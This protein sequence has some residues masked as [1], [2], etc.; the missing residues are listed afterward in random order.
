MQ[1]P[2]DL[3]PA[4]A[5][6]P[7][8]VLLNAQRHTSDLAPLIT[9][10]FLLLVLGHSLQALGYSSMPLLPLYLEH[11]QADRTEISLIMSTAA[12]SGILFRPLVGWSLDVFGRRPTLTVGTV[13]LVISMALIGLVDTIGPLI[14]A[15]RFLF[16]IGVG[17]LFTG[18]FAFVSD[19]IPVSR[20][21]EGIALFGVSGLA[22]LALNPVHQRLVGEPANLRWLYPGLAVIIFASLLCIWLIPEPNQATGEQDEP[23]PGVTVSDIVKALLEPRLWPVWWASVIFAGLVALFMTFATVVAEACGVEQPATLWVAYAGGA[24]GV[25]LFGARLPD[26]LGTRNLVA[27]AL[28]CYVVAFMLAAGASSA[29]GFI[30]AGLL[31]GLGHGYC[32]PVLTS[33]VVSRSPDHLRGSALAM[34]TALWDASKLA[35]MPLFGNVSDRLGDA[36]MFSMVAV[37][38]LAALVAWAGLEHRLGEAPSQAESG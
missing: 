10:A 34:F 1:P 22:P 15:A 4:G 17:A 23:R 8:E 30:V 9:A 38:A 20:R 36:V 5:P 26:R 13:I 12:V 31:A 29:T 24:I 32:F 19:I 6:H 37:T 7:H 33:Q 18:Y 2:P 16:G 14:Y 11:L 28:G 25:R 27:P 21:T 35:L 3:A